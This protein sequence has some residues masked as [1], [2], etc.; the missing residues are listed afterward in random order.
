MKALEDPYK[1]W[2]ACCWRSLA[3]AKGPALA[4]PVTRKCHARHL[5]SSEA[6][7]AA[8]EWRL[9]QRRCSI[10]CGMLGSTGKNAKKHNTHSKILDGFHVDGSTIGRVFDTGCCCCCCGIPRPVAII[11]KDCT[12]SESL[13]VAPI[14]DDDIGGVGCPL[15]PICCCPC[16]PSRLCWSMDGR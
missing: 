9:P 3:E 5:I 13:F 7:E 8:A 4:C 11:T 6:A 1:R 12:P 14:D 2:Q 10:D 16:D 15:Y